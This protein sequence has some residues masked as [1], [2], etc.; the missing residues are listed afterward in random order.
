MLDMGGTTGHKS[1]RVDQK[2]K[3]RKLMGPPSHLPQ[4]DRTSSH[5]SPP[6][7]PGWPGTLSQ[8]KPSSYS[9]FPSGICNNS[10][11]LSPWGKKAEKGIKATRIGL[12]S[13]L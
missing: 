11:K 12:N 6:S 8:K 9:C 2:G 3:G 7:R 13:K 5:A 10:K 4:T 1:P